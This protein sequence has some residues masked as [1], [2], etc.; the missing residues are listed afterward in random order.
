ARS[1]R[2]STPASPAAL[3]RT[4]LHAEHVALGAKMVPFA[5]W[6]MPVQYSGGTE[7]HRAVRAAAGLFD[8]SHMGQLVLSGEYAAQVVD[9]L[10]TNDAGH[11][12][13]GQALYTVAC[14]E[15]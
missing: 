4:P 10:V 2:V 14:N 8:V 15:H 5:G 6:E 1:R 13:D 7:E 9:Y 12:A 11:L 3:H